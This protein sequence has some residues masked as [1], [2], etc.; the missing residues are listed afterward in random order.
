MNLLHSYAEIIVNS[1]TFCALCQQYHP[2]LE[3]AKENPRVT[4]IPVIVHIRHLLSS[5]E[6]KGTCWV[7]IKSYIINSVCLVVVPSF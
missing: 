2:S 7:L 1:N 6:C 3:N 4:A 5:M